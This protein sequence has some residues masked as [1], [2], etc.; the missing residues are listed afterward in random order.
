[1]TSVQRLRILAGAGDPDDVLS[2]RI[3]V[4]AAA[5]ALVDSW[6]GG[7]MDGAHLAAIDGAEDRLAIAVRRYKTS[8]RRRQRALG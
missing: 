4:V 8:L 6:T 1:M 7:K 2:R 3:D 5:V